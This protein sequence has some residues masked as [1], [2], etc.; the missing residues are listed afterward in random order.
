[1]KN[2][3]L[4]I[5]LLLFVLVIFINFSE[6]RLEI[7]TSSKHIL[8]Q[9]IENFDDM[10][11]DSTN[12]DTAFRQLTYGDNVF[13]SEAEATP[14]LNFNYTFDRLYTD[15]VVFVI[16][17]TKV[18]E[19]TLSYEDILHK[20]YKIN[21]DF[22]EKIDENM[23][24][25]PKTHHIVLSMANALYGNIVSKEVYND[26]NKIHLENRFFVCDLNHDIT[27]TL[28][29]DALK[30][31]EENENFEIIVPSDDVLY[32]DYGIL[33]HN[34][35]DIFYNFSENNKLVL[36]DNVENKMSNFT[37]YINE[38]RKVSKNL[39]QISF[40]TNAYS[41]ANAKEITAFFLLLLFLLIVYLVFLTHRIT[42]KKI[43]F[44][45]KL[46]FFTQI[47]F[48]T[49]G[50]LKSISYESAAFEIIVWYLYY[51]P[52]LMLPACLVYI[53]FHTSYTGKKSF[54]DKFYKIYLGFCVF[55]FF[56]VFTNNTHELI[57]EVEIFS[58][59][60]YTYSYNIGYY[61]VISFVMISFAVSLISLIFKSFSS[62]KKVAFLYPV[63][64][65]IL[66][67]IYIVC[68]ITGVQ[69]VREF[70]LSYGNT[71]FLFLY[72]E[73]CMRSRLFPNNKGYDKLFANSSLAMKITDKNGKII[74]N[75]AI[76]LSIDENFVPKETEIIGGHFCYFEDYTSI[77]NAL[78]KLAEINE[79]LKKNKDF[80]IE[81]AS[82]HSDILALNA[83]QTVY[84]NI[85][86]TL[87][88]GINRAKIELFK[89]KENPLNKKPLLKINAIICMMKRDCMFR[90]NMLYLKK[91]QLGI[92]ISSLNE[93]KNFVAP[94]NIFINSRVTMSV[95]PKCVLSMYNFFSETVL[96]ALDFG[97][98]NLVV[99]LY[100]KDENLV[101]SIMSANEIFTEN[102]IFSFNQT[103]YYEAKYKTLDEG[104]SYILKFREED[105]DV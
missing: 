8:S 12:H 44:S 64:V 82:I 76:S 84:V 52:I 59:S 89:L 13:L 9:F 29:S 60:Y 20:D 72:A 30:I 62:P 2:F 78:G 51:I 56:L 25:H 45:L 66:L 33:R 104:F 74:D 53:T 36:I 47:L 3:L 42:D 97:A 83:K 24:E 31:T 65:N 71:I 50:V 96:R 87:I 26:I 41:F 7:N 49:L 23:W 101:F 92:F 75:S 58:P 77:N 35:S 32:I 81:N 85:D 28:F 17:T 22:P 43:L 38:S 99:Q 39:M 102:E 55:L 37:E 86:K 34:D 105:I 70:E 27:I 14:L 93:I 73:T 91:Q 88:S 6:N 90:I 103:T 95:H 94:M 19:K 21:F 15:Y 98:D 18:S 1:M 40:E 46:A 11:V 69:I 5:I 79:K 48:I 4:P 100:E 67:T 68:Y 10:S 54:F 63:I 57:F 61:F 80:L 16:D